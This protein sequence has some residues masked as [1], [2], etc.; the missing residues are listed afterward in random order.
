MSFVCAM[1]PPI[2]VDSPF[3]LALRSFKI[4][5]HFKRFNTLLVVL[6][7]TGGR[8]GSDHYA[9]RAS[10]DGGTNKAGFQYRTVSIIR[11]LVSK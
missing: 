8:S 11:S 7:S 6:E 5:R 10:S 1:N 3:S 9:F 4:I 2:I